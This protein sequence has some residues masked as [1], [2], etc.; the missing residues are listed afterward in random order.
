M[1]DEKSSIKHRVVKR[2]LFGRKSRL[3]LKF[4]LI[5]TIVAIALYML[6]DDSQK[7]T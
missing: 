7:H 1:A 6:S 5:L 4:G 3:A 2:R